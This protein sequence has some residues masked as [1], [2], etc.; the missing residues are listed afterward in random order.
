MPTQ[1]HQ[2]IILYILSSFQVVLY[3]NIKIL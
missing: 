3:Y 2:N 1:D